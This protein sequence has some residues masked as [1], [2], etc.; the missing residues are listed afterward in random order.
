[1]DFSGVGKISEKDL[2]YAAASDAV[3]F[4]FGIRTPGQIK[5]QAKT[6]GINIYESQIIYEAIDCARELMIDKLEPICREKSLGMAEVRQ[7]FPSNAGNVC[8]CRVLR[9]KVSRNA[10]L[11]VTRE[12]ETIHDGQILSLRVFKEDVSEVKKDQECGIVVD[13]GDVEVGD[14]LEIIEIEKIRPTL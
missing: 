12:G 11:R 2:K 8:G 10:H 5:N 14:H 4:A 7:I 6:L 9:G 13:Y 3:I 1:M